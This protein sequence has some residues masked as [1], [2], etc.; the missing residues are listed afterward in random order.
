MAYEVGQETMN[1]MLICQVAN[2]FAWEPHVK[3]IEVHTCKLVPISI[4]AQTRV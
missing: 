4:E 3:R 2:T 1:V